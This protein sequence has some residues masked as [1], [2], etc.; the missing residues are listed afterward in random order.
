MTQAWE[1]EKAY[2]KRRAEGIAC[3]LEQAI[4]NRDRDGFSKAYSIAMRYM[5]KRER[6]PYYKRFLT[7]MTEGGKQA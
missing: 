6:A 7:A 2:R 4:A 1:K 3:E 5:T